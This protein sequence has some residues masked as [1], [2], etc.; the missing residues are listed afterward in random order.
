MTLKQVLH[1]EYKKEIKPLEEVKNRRDCYRIHTNRHGRN[2]CFLTRRA[3]NEYAIRNL[4]RWR[5][6]SAMAWIVIMTTGLGIL[7]KYLDYIKGI[8][9]AI[10]FTI[11]FLIYWYAKGMERITWGWVDDDQNINNPKADK[12]NTKGVW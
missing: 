7:F 10:V 11:A 6:I 3:W 2:L 1:L 9:M 12:K 8:Y 4:N 5:I